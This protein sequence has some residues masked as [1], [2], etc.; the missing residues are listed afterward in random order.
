MKDYTYLFKNRNFIYLW[1]SQILSQLAINIMNFL[2]LT[3]L[4]SVTN[5]SIATSFLWV[6][7]SLPA[8][9]LGP[10]ASAYVDMADKKRLL[11]VTNFLQFLVIFT[12]AFTFNYNIFL[13]YGVAMAYSFLNQF[14]VPSESASLPS[15]I[16]KR[17]LPFANGLFFITQQF[18][19]IAGF[20]FAGILSQLL[21]FQ[22]AL[23][24]CSLFLLTAFVSVS[25]LPK[26]R[27][28]DLTV[29][30]LDKL[31]F[32]FFY[33]I[34]EGYDFIKANNRVLFPFLLLLGMQVG[35]SI[36]VVNIPLIAQ[37]ILSIHADKA[38]VLVIVPAG[39]GASVGAIYIPNILRKLNIRKKKVVE[40]SL[41]LLAVSI[42]LLSFLFLWLYGT[43]K[44]VISL[45]ILITMGSSFMGV[46]IPTQTFLQEVVP[47]G[48]RGRI[49]GNFWFLVTVASVFP[50]IFSGALSEFLGVRFLLFIFAAVSFTAFIFIKKKGDD[51]IGK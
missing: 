1:S 23:I 24:L 18:A 33:R 28:I 21:G 19:V 49:F 44:F 29:K 15:L 10:F 20:G 16:K 7:Y 27:S 42:F 50:V 48:L 4:F 30:S 3:R 12:Y 34:K 36:I 8:I 26:T 47:G 39:I 38:G 5:S 45:I 17:D 31:I 32:D 2:L 6:A 9:L 51:L 11:I 41:A 14:Y 25:F 13:A 43:F 46:I 35:L 40:I 37:E 22:G